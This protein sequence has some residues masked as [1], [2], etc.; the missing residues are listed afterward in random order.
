M[1]SLALGNKDK[2]ILFVGK[3]YSEYGGLPQ[4][5]TEETLCAAF[6][7]FGVITEVNL[8]NDPK[9]HNIHRG[10]GFV[11]FEDP[12]DAAAALDNM[13]RSEMFGRTIHVKVA[14]PGK[15][16]EKSSRAIWN[17]EG[18]L[19]K[20]AIGS[21]DI[22]D[23]VEDASLQTNNPKVFIELEISGRPAG[24]VEMELRADVVP[25]T[26]E[27]FRQL[28][29]HRVIP[30]FMCQ[31]GDFENGNG[32]GGKSIYGKKFEDEN[33][34]LKH[35]EAGL[36]SMANSGPGTNGSQFF[37]TL[38]KTPW[39]D[40][41]HVVFGKVTSGMEIVRMM[42]A[43]GSKAGKTSKEISVAGCGEI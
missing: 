13:N 32:T 31:G 8:P 35:D 19:E 41:K 7:P 21:T 39:L 36:L 4:E 26:A 33:F 11:E 40:G 30:Q 10:F 37:I 23:Q 5:V 24:R 6:L 42:E 16:F 15:M 2:S 25:R 38:D 17:E 34:I 27:N 18:W 3:T 1:S 43:L 22:K 9:T 29:F 14:R 28:V 12:D 20:H